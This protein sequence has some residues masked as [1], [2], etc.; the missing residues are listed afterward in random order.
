M[1]TT[2]YIATKAYRGIFEAFEPITVIEPSVR[3]A[4]EQEMVAQAPNLVVSSHAARW[5]LD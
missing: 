3:E 1:A 5:R 2:S 4:L